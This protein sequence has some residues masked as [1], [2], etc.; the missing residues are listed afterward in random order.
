MTQGRKQ[1]PIAGLSAIFL[2]ALAG[3]SAAEDVVRLPG[4]G[5]LKEVLPQIAE[6]ERLA[7]G[8][9][10]L[11][12][13]DGNADGRV[14]AEEFETGLTAS[15][16]AADANGDGSLSV[17][18]Q[19]DWADDLP[20]RDGSLSNPVRFDP[21]LD[22]VVSYD[23]F[24]SV[25]RSLA[26]PYQ[27]ETDGSIDLADLKLAKPRPESIAENRRPPLDRRPRLPRQ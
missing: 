4:Q 24:T 19:R 5:E 6:Q 17:F 22:R 25:I 18:E 20:T 8:G 10:L 23:E 12:S 3:P 11:V 9:G 15:F 7:P 26:A 14:S 16:A 21:N 27:D 1:W 2:V 13:F